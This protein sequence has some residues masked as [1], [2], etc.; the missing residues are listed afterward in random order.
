MRMVQSVVSCWAFG[1]AC[2]YKAFVYTLEFFIVIIEVKGKWT[3]GFILIYHSLIVLPIS[4]EIVVELLAATCHHI[5]DITRSF[6]LELPQ[7]S[8]Q[9]I[10]WVIIVEMDLCCVPLQYLILLCLICPDLGRIAQFSSCNVKIFANN[11]IIQSTNYRCHDTV[12]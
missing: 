3:A 9:L 7:V 6:C 4:L 8:H 2:Q 5:M 12:V 10:S 11:F 1:M